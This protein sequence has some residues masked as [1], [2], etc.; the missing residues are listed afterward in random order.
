VNYNEDK[1]QIYGMSIWSSSN[2]Y[3][4]IVLIYILWIQ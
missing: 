2:E 3:M 1:R 4:L